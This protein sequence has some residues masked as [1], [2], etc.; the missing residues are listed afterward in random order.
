MTWSILYVFISICAAALTAIATP[1]C[2]RLSWQLNFLD[3]PLGEMH[4]K[5][6]RATPLLGGPAMAA[7]WLLT[8]LSGVFVVFVFRSHL[9]EAL[10][11]QIPG[12]HSV[13]QLLCVISGGGIALA[14]M[15]LID[16]RA[17]MGPFIKLAFQMLICGAV[18]MYPKVRITLFIE[19][20]VATWLLT[21]CWFMFIIN[22]FNFFDNMDGLAS[23]VAVIAAGLFTVVAG[24]RQQFFVAA[25][26]AAT[27]GAALGFYLYNHHPAS[28]FMGDSGSH[29]LGYLLA[30]IGSL[31]MFYN[32][33]SSP[34]PAP[35]L[36][37]LL[38]LAVPIF[39]VFAVVLIRHRSGKPIYCGDHNHISHRFVQMGADQETAVFLVHLLT[40]AI[41]LGAVTLLWLDARG[42]IVVFI[43]T[44]AVLLLV[45]ILHR[46]GNG[47]RA[48]T[49][50]PS[51]ETSS[52]DDDEPIQ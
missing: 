12:I 31:T 3:N 45:S 25:L 41:G 29:F 51:V 17:P 34:T 35:L 27:A 24:S 40:L 30:V 33:E 4:K 28:I 10:A 37:P 13:Q 2:R 5:H 1:I 6:R 21:V 32:P 43:Q 46:S 38:V 50:V 14:T 44:V 11:N 19:S 49:P 20:P 15:G 42:V 23:G 22:A 18:A 39:D 8:I 9:P 52:A 48:N 7:G 16:D 36:I 26:G 47:A